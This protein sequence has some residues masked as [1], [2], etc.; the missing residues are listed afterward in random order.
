MD[1]DLLRRC[2][3]PTRRFDIQLAGAKT[4][5][6]KVDA[7]DLLQLGW[8]GFFMPLLHAWSSRSFRCEKRIH[9]AK[10]IVVLKFGSY[11]LRLVAD[12][13]AAVHEIYRWYR[14]GARILAVV[15]AI[16]ERPKSGSRRPDRWPRVRHRAA[17][18]LF[19]KCPCVDCDRNDWIGQVSF[20]AI[21]SGTRPGHR[22]PRMECTAVEPA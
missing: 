18:C 11:V 7:G 12:L 21:A 6:A 2:N 1:N 5:A 19:A 16:G 15:S 20:E 9:A 8:A 14:D 22:E 17:A 4:N 10:K 13:P 3:T